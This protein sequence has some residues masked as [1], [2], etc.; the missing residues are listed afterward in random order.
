MS[1]AQVASIRSGSVIG[2]LEV[3]QGGNVEGAVAGEVVERHGVTIVGHRNVPSRRAADNS[4]LF[5][6]NLYN[7][8]SAFW[9][10]DYAAEGASNL[11]G[12]HYRQLDLSDLNGVAGIN[13]RFDALDTPIPRS[14]ERRVGKEGVSTGRSRWSP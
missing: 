8:L 10:K 2:G 1:G 7:F 4:A 13:P 11:T 9:D 12:L 14:E 5:A 6:R 3:E